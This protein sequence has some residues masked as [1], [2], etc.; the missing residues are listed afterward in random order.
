[1]Q[2]LV[3]CALKKHARED[4]EQVLL[5][6]KSYYFL[7]QYLWAINYCLGKSKNRVSICNTSPKFSPS[8]HLL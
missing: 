4:V 3:D 6:S 8:L 5:L 7:V 2:T 1:M